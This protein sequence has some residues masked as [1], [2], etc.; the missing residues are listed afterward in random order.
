MSKP[1]AVATVPTCRSYPCWP[2]PMTPCC[3][4]PS[5][6][7]RL[8]PKSLG[9]N[10]GHEDGHPRNINFRL[11]VKREPYQWGARR[12]SAV[13]RISTGRTGRRS[14][15]RWSMR[16]LRCLRSFARWISASLIGHGTAHRVQRAGSVA[17]CRGERPANCTAEAGPCDTACLPKKVLMGT[18]VR[19]R[20]PCGPGRIASNSECGEQP[21]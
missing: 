17:V 7:V 11:S 15:V 4:N 5:Q 16:A 2:Q 14:R 3:L 8:V 19:G 13:T 6:H 18:R 21:A 9:H 10:H 20:R 12:R 1:S